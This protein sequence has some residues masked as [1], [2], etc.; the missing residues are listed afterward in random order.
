M[1]EYYGITSKEK[2]RSLFI[3]HCTTEICEI[4]IL[5]IVGVCHVY[6]E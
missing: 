2:K 1:I 6:A 3:I 4:S 5:V